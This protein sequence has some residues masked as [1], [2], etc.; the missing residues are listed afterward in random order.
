MTSGLS[1]LLKRNRLSQ[2]E[3]ARGIGRSSAFISQLIHGKTGASQETVA[4][5][6]R[7]LSA[8]LG[9]RVTYEGAFGSPVE[10]RIRRAS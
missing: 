10:Q 1:G 4:D 7:F 3:L 9:R 2:A 8:R 5:I 6:L